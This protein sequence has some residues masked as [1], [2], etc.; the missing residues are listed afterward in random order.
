MQIADSYIYFI[1]VLGLFKNNLQLSQCYLVLEKNA[2]NC[3]HSNRELVTMSS[4]NGWHESY[5]SEFA[6]SQVLLPLMNYTHSWFSSNIH[7]QD[8]KIFFLKTWESN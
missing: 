4:L 3:S 1:L 2:F 7:L 6:A 8:R 5:L